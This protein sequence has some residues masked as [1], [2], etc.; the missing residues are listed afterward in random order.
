M[1]VHAHHASQRLKPE[2]IAEARQ[3]FSGAIAC[4]DVLRNGS[5]EFLHPLRK[6]RRYTAAVQRK[7][8][9]SGALHEYNSSVTGCRTRPVSQVSERFDGLCG[10]RQSCLSGCS[11]QILS[12]ELAI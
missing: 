2:W 12:G 3:K 8:S 9:K 5:T 11:F 1:P 7:I 4:D 6:P 10:D